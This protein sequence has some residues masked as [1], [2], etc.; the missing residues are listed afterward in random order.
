MA[1]TD[2]SDDRLDPVARQI[3][4][5]LA[6]REPGKTI[7]PSDAARAFFEARR[8][9]GDPVDGWRGYMH[10][11]NQQAR[12]LAR[13]GRIEI[14]RRGDVQDPHKPVKGVI[15]LRLPQDS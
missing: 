5:L 12:F 3:L 4:D 11:A 13:Q 15:R 2:D 9:S 7:C 10:A 14:L 6:A 8:K 1:R